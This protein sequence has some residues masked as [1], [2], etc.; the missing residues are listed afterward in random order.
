[1]EVFG[2]SPLPGLGLQRE[3]QGGDRISMIL[4]KIIRGA[5]GGQTGRVGTG[6][7]RGWA[8]L[9]GDESSG[10]GVYPGSPPY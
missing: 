9:P 8:I 10:Q 3:G 7:G 6:D 4:K 1:M 2:G 5:V